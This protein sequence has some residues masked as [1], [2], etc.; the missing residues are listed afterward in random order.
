M[1]TMMRLV[2]LVSIVGVL[3]GCSLY[4][5][6]VENEYNRLLNLPEA[7]HQDMECPQNINEL[8]KQACVYRNLRLRYMRAYVTEMEFHRVGVG[9]ENDVQNFI[10]ET[11][12]SPEEAFEQVKAMIIEGDLNLS[13]EGKVW[14]QVASWLA[15]RKELVEVKKPMRKHRS[16]VEKAYYDLSQSYS[17]RYKEI[18]KRMKENSRNKRDESCDDYTLRQYEQIRAEMKC[19]DVVYSRI[20]DADDCS[21]V[22]FEMERRKSVLRSYNK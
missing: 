5:Q 18:K 6:Y 16:R 13:E 4:R 11:N 1:Q 10:Q 8:D 21:L 17:E 20:K 3:S 9:F 12:V 15:A 14:P 2:L 22:E 19:L 7:I